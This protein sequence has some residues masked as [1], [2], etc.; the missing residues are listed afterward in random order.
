MTQLHVD[1]KEFIR[2]AGIAALGAGTIPLIVK[3]SLGA[4]MLYKTV[5]PFSI[6][7]DPSTLTVSWIN[8]AGVT[9]GTGRVLPSTG[10]IQIAPSNSAAYMISPPTGTQNGVWYNVGYGISVATTSPTVGNFNSS[11]TGAGVWQKVSTTQAQLGYAASKSGPVYTDDPGYAVVNLTNYDKRGCGGHNCYAPTQW[12]RKT[13][14]QSSQTQQ[15]AQDLVNWT[16]ATVGATIA[17]VALDDCW[18]SGP[19][20]PEDCTLAAAAFAIALIA[21]TEEVITYF[22]NCVLAL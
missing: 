22:N 8:N 15:C 11:G 18:A 19:F 4:P 7:R 10:Q 9:L 1:R 17:A 5:G 13:S 20:A 16:M 14:P 12:S 6:Y 3:P 21:Y 2:I